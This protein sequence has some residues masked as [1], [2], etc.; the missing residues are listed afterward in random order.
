MSSVDPEVSTDPFD[1]CGPRM[2]PFDSKST[3]SVD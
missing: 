3:R 2:S 1:R